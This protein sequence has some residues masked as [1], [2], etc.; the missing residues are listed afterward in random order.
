MMDQRMNPV[1]WII[2]LV[3]LGALIIG[4]LAW[5]LGNRDPAPP[6]LASPVPAMISPAPVETGLPEQ[7]APVPAAASVPAQSAA[8]AP[9]TTTSSTTATSPTT[10]TSAVTPPPAASPEQQ[11]ALMQAQLEDTRKLTELKEQQIQALE[12]ELAALS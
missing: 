6:P 11:K 7:A 8:S 5:W 10:A 12:Q 9:A 3:T 4:A 2:L 1:M